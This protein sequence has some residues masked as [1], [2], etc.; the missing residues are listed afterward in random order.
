MRRTLFLGVLLMVGIAVFAGLGQSA[1]AQEPPVPVIVPSC[2]DVARYDLNRDG[3]V[4][5]DDFSL[6]VITVHE[7]GGPA[8]QLNGPASG[9]PVWLDVN[10]DG[11]ISHADL[12]AMSLFRANCVW[13]SRSVR[14]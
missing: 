6:W 13:P 4:S 9:C 2:Q 10:R 1:R 5:A 12:D 8:C 3:R 14:R 11:V 7:L